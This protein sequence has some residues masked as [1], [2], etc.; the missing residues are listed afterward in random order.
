MKLIAL[1]LALL[2]ALALTTFAQANSDL[3]RASTRTVRYT[4]GQT[5][6]IVGQVLQNLP[7]GLII[8]CTPR[9][10]GQS[11]AKRAEDTIF[12]RGDYRIN[13]GQSVDFT[14]TVDG[15]YNY[16]TVTNS[17]QIIPAFQARK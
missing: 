15:E 12:L 2:G 4:P 10:T 1:T 17:R 13:Q 5:V 9:Q 11:G 8:I 16:T 14:A 7:D 3:Q 6:R